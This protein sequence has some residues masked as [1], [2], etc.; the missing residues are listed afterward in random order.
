MGEAGQGRMTTS[1]ADEA[2]ARGPDRV[3]QPLPAAA[4]AT[5]RRPRSR[6][7]SRARTRRRCATC[8]PAAPHSAPTCR[9]AA[10][11]PRR[12]PCPNRALGRLRAARR[13]QGDEHDDGL[14]A[15]VLGRAAE[16]AALGP[17]VVPIVAD[18]A[19]TFGMANLFKQVAIYSNVGQNAR[20]RGHWLVLRY[21]EATTAR[22]SRRASAKPGAEL[23]VAAATSYWC[24]APRCCPSTSTTRC[25]A[26]SASAT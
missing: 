4:G 16:D 2:R 19:R 6:S 21:R 20:A 17:R 24:A 26:S 11:T 3:P 9:P 14:R 15:A 25:S 8:T 5:S 7:S 1:P 13:R 22:S 18:E 12:C 23:V 10:A